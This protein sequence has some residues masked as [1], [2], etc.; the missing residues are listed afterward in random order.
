MQMFVFFCET[1]KYLQTLKERHF[2][3]ITTSYSVTMCVTYFSD[4]I[5]DMKLVE[6]INH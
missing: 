4:V 3:Q 1:K 2:L 6:L 5:L